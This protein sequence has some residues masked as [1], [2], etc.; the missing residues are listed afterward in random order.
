MLGRSFNDIFSSKPLQYPWGDTLLILKNSDITIGNLETTITNSDVK[1][2]DKAY[3]FKL[4]PKYAKT[5]KIANFSYCSLANNHILDYEVD[6]MNDTIN[7]L[8]KL[9]IKHAGAGKNIK[10][11]MQPVFINKNDIKF[12]FL[13]AADHYDYWEAKNNMPGI[14]YIPIRNSELS[15]WDMVFEKVREVKTRCD[16]LIFSLHWNYNY[17]DQIG[18]KFISFGHK[19]INNGV[20]IIHGHS[21]HHILPLEIYKNGIIFYSLGDFIDDYSIKKKYRNDLSVMIKIVIERDFKDLKMRIDEIYPT[22]IK[23]MQVDLVT[24]KNDVTFINKQ[25]EEIK[26]NY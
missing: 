23:N 21:P 13:S 5:L 20:D 7:N 2:P 12:G 16:V 11:A 15:D 26:L 8:D 17:V 14:W 25:L 4:L 18:E 22:K 10:K 3:N 1:W 19:L 24:S 9:K 6:G